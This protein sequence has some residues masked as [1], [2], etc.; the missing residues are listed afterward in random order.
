MSLDFSGRHFKSE[1]IM[2]AV[3]WYLSYS[4]SYREVEELLLERGIKVDHSTIQRW[5][6][7]Y[8]HELES[9]FR[10]KHKRS[11]NYTSW[12]MD[13]TYVK[14]NG[15]W[16][17]LYRAIDKEGDTIDFMF[18]ETRDEKAAFAFLKKAI[19]G[20][21]LPDKITID[22]SSANEAAIL[23][24]NMMLCIAGLWPYI[25]VEERQVKYLN[26]RI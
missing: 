14:L 11:G 24:L 6:E 2:M 13:E 9:V 19:G 17:F 10:R 1:I 4:L 25:W 8:A 23:Q 21:A 16:G 20:H 15:V 26:N 18:S 3:R 12:R 7:R 22:G 5:V